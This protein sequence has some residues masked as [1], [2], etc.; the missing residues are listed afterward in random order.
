L[1]ILFSASAALLFVCL[2]YLVWRPQMQT[3]SVVQA[4]RVPVKLEEEFASDPRMQRLLLAATQGQAGQ[5]QA[6]TAEGADINQPGD[7]YQ[8]TPLMWAVMHGSADGVRLLLSLG[9]DPNK[10]V[11]HVTEDEIDRRFEELRH[12]DPSLTHGRLASRLITFAGDS[13]LRG[14][15][16]TSPRRS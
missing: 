13:A 3:G 14:C 11:P 16:K 6:M 1:I 12:E 2:V 7:F 10:R 8:L 4:G 15:E 5:V 9:A